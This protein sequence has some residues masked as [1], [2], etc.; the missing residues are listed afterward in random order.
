MSL[1]AENYNCFKFHMSQDN[2]PSRTLLS[3]A[4][5]KRLSR[6]KDTTE[7]RAIRQ[8]KQREERDR[9]D[10]ITLIKSEVSARKD[11]RPD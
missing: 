11:P 6:E 3:E 9:R 10:R 4:K 2:L 1:V 5:R 8:E 7:E